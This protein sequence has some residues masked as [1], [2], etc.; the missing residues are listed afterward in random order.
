VLERAVAAGRLRRMSSTQ[1]RIGL[2]ATE[3]AG[4][5]AEAARATKAGLRD[6]RFLRAATGR[7]LPLHVSRTTIDADES[8]RWLP[9]GI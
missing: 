5:Q 9:G 4:G 6:Q 7:T 1:I 8:A 2:G 3:A